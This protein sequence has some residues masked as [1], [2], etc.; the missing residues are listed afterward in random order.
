MTCKVTRDENGN[1]CIVCTRSSMQLCG[2]GH[3]STLLCDFELKG[4]KDGQTCDRP[5]CERCSTKIDSKDLC[6][7]HRRLIQNK[8]VQQSAKDAMKNW[9]AWKKEYR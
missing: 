1:P 5:L 2:C 8:K 4:E 9:P 7:A 3:K 6:P